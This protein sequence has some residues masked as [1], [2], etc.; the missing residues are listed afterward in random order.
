M[1]C[2]YYND[3]EKNSVLQNDSIVN[4]GFFKCRLYLC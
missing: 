4:S 3:S 1:Y 2:E